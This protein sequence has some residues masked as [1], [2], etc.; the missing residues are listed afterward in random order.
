MVPKVDLIP[1]EMSVNSA[2]K[3]IISGGL[4]YPE[5]EIEKT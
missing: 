4:I 3:L 5:K 2:I 1:L